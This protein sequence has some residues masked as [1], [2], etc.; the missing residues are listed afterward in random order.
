MNFSL[1][2]T[3]IGFVL[4]AYSV[5]GND[6]IQTLGTFLASNKERFKWYTLWFAASVAMSFTLIFGWYFYDG[7]ISYERLTQIPYQEIKWYHA[8]APAALLSGT[9]FASGILNIFEIATYKLPDYSI[10][11]CLFKFSIN[12]NIS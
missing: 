3:I 2:Y 12:F 9:L 1:L 4:A 10:N 6:S 8:M 7:D 11:F 5:I